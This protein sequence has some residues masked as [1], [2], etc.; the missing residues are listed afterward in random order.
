MG[1]KDGGWSVGAGGSTA[2]GDFLHLSRVQGLG[3]RAFF[4]GSLVGSYPLANTLQAWKKAIAAILPA[5]PQMPTLRSGICAAV[6]AAL[7]SW[8]VYFG[9][10]KKPSGRDTRRPWRGYQQLLRVGAVCVGAVCLVGC[11][12]SEQV[13]DL[14]SDLSSGVARE[15]NQ[16]ALKLARCGEKASRAV[17]VLE[18][19]LYDENVGVQSSAAYALRKIDTPAAR[20]IME[21]IDQERRSR[22]GS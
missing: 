9:R 20:R 2:I 16:A 13:P 8:P 14:I 15:R 18:Q 5:W 3:V 19:L 12:N 11:C 17:P 1:I 6:R 10:V 7:I 4:T 21:R 22:R